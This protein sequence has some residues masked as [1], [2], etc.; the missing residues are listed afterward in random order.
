M[1]S[2]S[3]LYYGKS[4]FALSECWSL[5][6]IHGSAKRLVPGCMNHRENLR[7]HSCTANGPKN[8]AWSPNQSRWIVYQSGKCTIWISIISPLSSSRSRNL[9]VGLGQDDDDRGGECTRRERGRDEGDG[10]A[11]PRF[12]FWVAKRVGS[13]ARL[14]FAQCTLECILINE[15]SLKNKGNLRY[16]ST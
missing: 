15:K 6:R 14:G 16:N 9:L 11:V 12:R 8:T 13:Y 7:F 1:N 3:F 10:A 2:E 5:I 4:S